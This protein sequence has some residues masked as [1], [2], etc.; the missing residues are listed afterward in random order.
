MFVVAKHRGDVP[1][2]VRTIFCRGYEPVFVTV[3]LT[4]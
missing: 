1:V 2:L 4:E 3:I